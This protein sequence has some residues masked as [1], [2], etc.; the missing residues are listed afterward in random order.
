M[1][2]SVISDWRSYTKKKEKKKSN[3]RALLSLFF[4]FFLSFLF[5]RFD[6]FNF[7]FVQCL[8]FGWFSFLVEQTSQLTLYGFRFDFLLM[9]CLGFLFTKYIPNSIHTKVTIF[10]SS[11][12]HSYSEEFRV[13][14]LLLLLFVV[15]LV[16][17]GFTDHFFCSSWWII[18]KE[19]WFWLND[20]MNWRGL[21]LH[22]LEGFILS[23]TWPGPILLG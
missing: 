6:V 12:F 1:Q 2:V 15:L 16:F 17:F 21:K 10:S 14:C 20:V 11:F 19:F 8:M 13:F 3:D 5:L 23:R 4:S 22:R 18:G 7:D 9:W